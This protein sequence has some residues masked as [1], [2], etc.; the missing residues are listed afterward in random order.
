MYYG[1]IKNCDIADGIGVRVSLFVSGCRHH[2]DGCFNAMTWDFE[3]GRPFTEET[4]NELLEM[5]SPDYID[6]LTLLGGEPMEPDNQRALVPF[7]RRVREKY[8]DKSIWC[9]TGCVL[10]DE[11]LRESTWR[12]EYTDEMLSMIDVLVD[13]RFILA[14]RNI[15][16][17]FRGSDNQRIIDL[18]K[19]LAQGNTITLDLD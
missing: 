6:G 1:E 19:T 18:K 15:S 4:E 10:E 5:L 13:G 3:Y 2:C 17:A 16:L 12:C 9:Y 8:P 14:R 7:M 11:L